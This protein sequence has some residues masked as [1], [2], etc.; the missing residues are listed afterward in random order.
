M[1]V[2]RH[3]AGLVR[4]TLA[5]G[6]PRP[7]GRWP[8]GEQPLHAR[9]GHALSVRSAEPNR[10]RDARRDTGSGSDSLVPTASRAACGGRDVLGTNSA[11]PLDW[12][13]MVEGCIR[14]YTQVIAEAGDRLGCLPMVPGVLRLT[15][16]PAGAGFSN[17]LGRRRCVDDGESMSA[18]R[19]QAAS[20]AFDFSTSALNASMSA[21]AT[22]E[23]ILRSTSMPALLRPSMKRE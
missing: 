2:R 5:P 16:N 21:I 22:S 23:S 9:A 17:S 15:K 13:G 19:A 14:Q 1:A 20:A 18:R 11:P 7:E 4:L 3:G 6:F 12:Q 10:Q 8:G